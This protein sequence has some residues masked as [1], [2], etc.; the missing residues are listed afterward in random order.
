MKKTLYIPILLVIIVVVIYG[1]SHYAPRIQPDAST[2]HPTL[3]APPRLSEEVKKIISNPT[4]LIEIYKDPLYP[5]SFRYPPGF[6]VNTV[7]D[8]DRY[9]LLL[10]D[11]GVKSGIQISLIPFDESADT[12]TQARIEKDIPGIVMQDVQPLLLGDSG[13]KGLAFR[14][15]NPLFGSS[16]EVWF[17][18]KGYLYQITTYTSQ[19]ELL[20]AI[21]NTWSLR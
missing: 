8:E 16:R 20:Q 15:N 13:G 7:S 17:V 2:L 3:P 4:N 18:Y 9:T 11:T 10:Q 1:I 21:M 12:L 6:K 14:S 19:D 5:F